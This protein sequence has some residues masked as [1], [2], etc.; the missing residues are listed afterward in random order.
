MSPLSHGGPGLGPLSARQQLVQGLKQPEVLARAGLST[1]NAVLRE[2]RAANL[3]ARL[4]HVLEQAGLQDSVPSPA[5]PHLLAARRLSQHQHDA[6]RWECRHLAHALGDLPIPV[7]LLK[8]SAY[9]MGGLAASRGRLFGDVDLLVPRQYLNQVEAAL[10]L[11]GWSAGAVDPYDDRY[12]RRWMHELPPFVHLKRGTTLDVHHNIL[13]LTA[14]DVPE[15]QELLDRSAALPDS[16]LRIPLR[17]DIVIHSAVHLF[18]EG[19]TVHALRDLLDLEA[20][21]TEF[22]EADPRFWD[23]LIERARRLHLVWP[24]YLA[25][26]YLACMLQLQIPS[27]V[28]AELRK[29]SGM[30]KL[31]LAVLDRLYR[32]AFFDNRTGQTGWGDALARGILYLRGHALRM[33]PHLLALHLARKGLFRLFKSSSRSI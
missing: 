15:A 1:W 28:Q 24:T 20:L 32:H 17:E 4:A 19:E 30:G 13:P 27:P 7:V 33:P 8:G 2:A 31:R 11:H 21:C 26:R 16:R 6:I 12:Y 14:A 9:V 5:R 23:R 3:M 22:A 29:G 18:H 10:R 25:V